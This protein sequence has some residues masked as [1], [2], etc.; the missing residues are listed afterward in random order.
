MPYIESG[1]LTAALSRAFESDVGLGLFELGASSQASALLHPT[2]A[3]WLEL[4]RAFVTAVT[5]VPN[6]DD[7]RPQITVPVDL[8][9]IETLTQRIPPMT[10]GEYLNAEVLISLWVRMEAA[11]QFVLRDHEDTVAGLLASRNAVWHVVGR[12]CFHLAE[13]KGD[14]SMPFAF[15]ATY[16]DRAGAGTTARH[17]PLG[18]ALAA[19]ADD[20]D[21]LLRL[22][23]PVQEAATRCAWVDA[24]VRSGDVYHPIAW[25]VAEAHRLLCDVPALEEAGLLVRLP[26]WWRA[27]SARPVVR[28]TVGDGQPGGFGLGALLDFKVQTVL[29][30]EVLT[31]EDWAQI[32]ESESGLVL[33]RGRW[34]EIDRARLDQV[35][36][37]W[38]DVARAAENGLSLGEGMRLVAG[39]DAPKNA[40]EDDASWSE[41]VAGRSLS[42][43]LTA[44]REP[45]AEAPKLGRALKANLRPYQQA[46]L[47]WLWTLDRLGL[48][49]CLA[50][51]MGLGKTL[52]VIALL[53][54]KK[55]AKS[56]G[57]A[58]IVAPASI[59]TN[60]QSEIERFAP[61][62]EV[63]VAH[64]SAMPRSELVDV[65]ATKIASADVVIVTYAAVGR[66]K[67]LPT[68]EWDVVVLDEAQAIKN[69]GTRQTRAVKALKSR[70]RVALT[71]TPIENRL[72]DL[73]SLFDFLAPGLLGGA[74]QFTKLTRHLAKSDRGYAPLRSLIRP[75]MLR[76]L[77]TD[78]RIIDDLPDKIEVNAYCSLSRTQAG[79]YQTA[80]DELA[81][82]LE[83]LSGTKRRGLVL[84]Y[85][86]RL[87]QICNHPSQ[88]LG[89]GE[90]ALKDSGKL[91][92]LGELCEA[93][94]SRQ[95]RVL[96]FSQFREMTGPLATFLA[97]VFN[98]PGLVLHGG[99]PVK[100]RR[101]LVDEPRSREGVRRASC[102]RP[103]RDLRRH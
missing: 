59:I 44:L 66:L 64:A 70:T 2:T 37:R 94:A 58:L 30:G 96:V 8:V 82:K 47:Q 95:E 61:T 43:A 1:A 78:S 35:L 38:T 18:R 28:V 14:E 12:V 69:P 16:A 72:S 101:N 80:V 103:S 21:G 49:G 46:G 10:G 76:R 86:M 83:T 93:I 27:K 32:R 102:P 3:F 71:G 39:I 55:K 50:D 100:K 77:K 99:T 87:K 60:W 57:P 56:S 41:V 62:L 89:D 45:A 4:G 79:H 7:M 54:L 34:V 5:R 25:S 84:A 19:Y 29:D 53:L 67:W 15:L 63:L 20:R 91:A 98:R 6:I 88:W 24:L 90:Y 22:L 51:D 74:S 13:N 36:E 17:V 42:E 85:L 48:G 52:Q 75:D 11:L 81:S 97:G 9:A 40:E 68:T 92:R 73:W 33:L 26:D 65:D 31:A 23:E